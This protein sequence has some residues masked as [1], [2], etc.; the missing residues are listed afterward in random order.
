MQIHFFH[1]KCPHCGEH[2]IPTFP[3][4]NQY[5]KTIKCKRC[6]KLVKCRKYLLRSI[7]FSD[8]TVTVWIVKALGEALELSLNLTAG[9]SV[10]FFLI[11]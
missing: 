3:K 10:I 5:K 8:V 1:S 4:S 11:Q 6:G 7:V 9:L 2:G